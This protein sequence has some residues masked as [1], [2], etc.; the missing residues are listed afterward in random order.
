MTATPTKP[1]RPA[2]VTIDAR[3]PQ[4]LEALHWL[5]GTIENEFRPVLE[6]AIF[7]TYDPEEG[8]YLAR[9]FA[10]LSQL[11]VDLRDADAKAVKPPAAKAS[12]SA[13][14]LPLL[15]VIDASG[16]GDGKPVKRKP[17]AAPTPR[18]PRWADGVE[19]GC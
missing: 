10:A 12:A 7:S 14:G 9:Q 2:R 18:F 11:L 19:C 15:G 4:D 5:L 16:E 1:A 13:F 6:E 3:S 17:A 8:M